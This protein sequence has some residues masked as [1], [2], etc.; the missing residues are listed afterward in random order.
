[1]N[2]EKRVLM[3]ENEMRALKQTIAQLQDMGPSPSVV[4]SDDEQLTVKSA[5]EEFNIGANLIYQALADN[6]LVY[7]RRGRSYLI[8]RLTMREWIASMQNQVQQQTEIEN[9][10]ASYLQKNPMR[11]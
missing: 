11:G 2:L 5:A 8:T 3:L 7:E 10:V 4:S 9:Y 6:K 1:M